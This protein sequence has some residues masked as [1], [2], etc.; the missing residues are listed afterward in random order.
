MLVE[1]TDILE[2][3]IFLMWKALQ[4]NPSHSSSLGVKALEL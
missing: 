3:C 1:L 2:M 4:R